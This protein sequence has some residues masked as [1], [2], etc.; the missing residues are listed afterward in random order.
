MVD[1]RQAQDAPIRGPGDHFF[2]AVL[3][4]HQ[5]LDK[6]RPLDW[7]TTGA[8]VIL[9]E[10]QVVAAGGFRGRFSS[11]GVI[12]LGGPHSLAGSASGSRR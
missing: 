10:P 6:D 1:P 3:P 11:S 7:Q 9:A 12:L 8:N 5:R 4:R 2:L